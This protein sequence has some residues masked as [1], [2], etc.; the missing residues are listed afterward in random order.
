MTRTRGRRCTA[1]FIALAAA[2]VST[3]CAAGT[4]GDGTGGAESIVVGHSWAKAQQEGDTAVFGMVMNAT[5]SDVTVLSAASNAARGVELHETGESADGQMV[6]AKI[7]GG[8]HLPAGKPLMLKPGG[9]HLML[10]GL[11]QPLQPGDEIAV[12]LT[13]ED[14]TEIPFVASVKDFSGAGETYVDE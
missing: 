10:V 1:L 12:T 3:S 7:A 6:M 2:T 9:D 8:F 14:G 4:N 11:V 13:L 5:S